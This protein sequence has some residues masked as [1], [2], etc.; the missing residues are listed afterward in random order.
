MDE[1][2][3]LVYGSSNRSLNSLTLKPRFSV[4]EVNV[5]MRSEEG[6]ERSKLIELHKEIISCFAVEAWNVSTTEGVTG[7]SELK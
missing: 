5:C 2:V 1:I 6:I 4:R 3:A 7:N